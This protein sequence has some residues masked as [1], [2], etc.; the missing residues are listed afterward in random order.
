MAVPH[1]L[2]VR[3]AIKEIE[4]LKEIL[5]H[6]I[7]SAIERGCNLLSTSGVRGAELREFL[8]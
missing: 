6:N 5:E 4:G 8:I 2:M 1:R 7:V 3:P